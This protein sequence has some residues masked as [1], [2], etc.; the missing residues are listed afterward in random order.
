MT[1]QVIFKIDKDLKKKA[2][3]KAAMDGFTYSDFLKSATRAYLADEFEFKLVPK[4]KEFVPTKKELVEL[5]KARA[6]YAAGKYVSWE[7]L[8]NELDHKHKI[9]GK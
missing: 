1:T 5:A 6:D 2:Q 9:K 3:K 8:K 7:A 4:V